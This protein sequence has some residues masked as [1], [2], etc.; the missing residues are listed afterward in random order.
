MKQ[1]NKGKV[2]ERKTSK[3]VN[4]ASGEIVNEWH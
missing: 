3:Q 2:S 1:M 4:K